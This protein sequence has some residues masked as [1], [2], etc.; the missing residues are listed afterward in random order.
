MAVEI[1]AFLAV[2]AFRYIF[3]TFF[4]FDVN[5]FLF[6]AKQ[7]LDST[8]LV[9]GDDFDDEP[10]ASHRSLVRAVGTRFPTTIIERIPEAANTEYREFPR[11]PILTMAAATRSGVVVFA[12]L[13]E[14]RIFRECNNSVGCRIGVCDGTRTRTEWFGKPRPLPIGIHTSL[15]M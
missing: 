14:G 7:T 2:D 12:R 11:W 8:H 6:L 13:R 3:G 10:M 4:A 9:F 15:F 5:V 1:R